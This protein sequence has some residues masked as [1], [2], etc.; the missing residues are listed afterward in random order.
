MT[1]NYLLVLVNVWNQIKYFKTMSIRIFYTLNI[2]LDLTFIVGNICTI[3]YFNKVE[4]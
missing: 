4:D 1:I 3:I 2:W